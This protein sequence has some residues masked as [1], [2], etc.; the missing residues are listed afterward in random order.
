MS[1]KNFIYG[2]R[3][4]IEAINSNQ[5]I[6]KVFFKKNLQSPQFSELFRLVRQKQILFQFVPPEKLDKITKGN[7]QGVIAFM[8]IVEYV[9]VG[10]II[11]SI[12]EKGQAPLILLLDGVTD[13]RN[14]GAIARSAECAGV[15]LIVVREKGSA[16]I[17]SDAVKTSAGALLRIP[18]AKVKSLSQTV[19]YL[20]FS[21][22]NILAATEKAKDTIYQID[23]SKPTAIVLGDEE[24]GISYQII[25]TAN[26]HA[27]IPIV[28]QIAS[29]NVS[30]AAS[31]II[32]E[33]LRQRL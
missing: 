21:G 17:S 33:A 16:Q 13:V 28:G 5:K 3:A 31:I 9:E 8:Q 23:F 26:Q 32:F 25:K 18:V 20:K 4:V 22:L 19:Q 1:E 7:H 24:K 15:H 30:N 29:L 27:K 6:E 10:D 11:Q 12:F 2:I 14:L